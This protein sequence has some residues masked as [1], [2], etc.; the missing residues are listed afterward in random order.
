MLTVFYFAIA[1][2]IIG[3][4][5][6]GILT[7]V[8]WRRSETSTIALPVL[9]GAAMVWV[10]SAAAEHLMPALEAKIL[11]SKVQ[12]LGIV[13][14]SPAAVCT[15]LAYIGREKWIGPFLMFAFPTAIFCWG[16]ALTNDL[17]HGLWR[18]VELT[19]SSG[20]S[21][22][23][24]SYGPMFWVI[25]VLSHGQLV[26][27]MTLF[28]IYSWKNWQLQST[29]VM[30]GFAAPWAANL[31]YVSGASPI[32]HLDITPFG[33]IVTGACFAY[34]FHAVGSIFS[35]VRVA[36]RDIVECIEDLIFVVDDRQRI[37]SANNSAHTILAP[38]PL[39]A[40][41][42]ILLAGQPNLLL[43]LQHGPTSHHRDIELEQGRDKTNFDVRPMAV[44]DQQGTN[45][46]T[47]YVLRDVTQERERESMLK[48]LASTD[49]LTN[50]PN[51]RHFQDV[52]SKALDRSMRAR[53]ACSP[54]LTGS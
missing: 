38:H 15:V 3:G 54:A 36:N 20:M 18:D 30:L 50:L 47:V 29:L 52:L 34:S 24:L 16:V 40:P 49:P 17:H 51:R 35:T 9:L 22:L 28:F 39:P 45:L 53:A 10:L 13:A 5:I 21:L 11:V 1:L 8:T 19:S 26:V 32:A 33:L 6:L 41:I 46:A 37:V 43:Y 48:F 14:L 27:A 4:L 25:T 23:S 31:L 12:Y 42:D 7:A 2:L 44:T